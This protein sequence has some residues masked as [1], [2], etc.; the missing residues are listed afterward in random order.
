MK[1][2]KPGRPL[3]ACPHLQSQQ[4]DCPKNKGC[5]C[6]NSITVAFPKRQG[7][8]DCKTGPKTI[9]KTEGRPSG[10]AI[11]D[12]PAITAGTFKIVKKSAPLA[13]GVSRP[14]PQSYD[15]TYF[16]A[17]GL[18]SCNIIQNGSPTTPASANGMGMNGMAPPQAPVQIAPALPNLYAQNTP[19]MPM[20]FYAGMLSNGQRPR[21]SISNGAGMPFAAA[22]SEAAGFSLSNSSY[23]NGTSDYMSNGIYMAN[24]HPPQPILTSPYPISTMSTPQSYSSS[25]N[26]TTPATTVKSCCSSKKSTNSSPDNLDMTSMSQIPLQQ[27]YNAPSFSNGNGPIYSAAGMQPAYAYTANFADPSQQM[28]NGQWS[29]NFGMSYSPQQPLQ[30]LQSSNRMFQLPTSALD[31]THE[32]QCACGPDCE[33]F[34][35]QVHPQ[36]ATTLAYVRNLHN[37]MSHAPSSRESTSPITPMQQSQDLFYMAQNQSQPQIFQPHLLQNFY[38][39]SLDK[40]P[41]VTATTMAMKSE[42]PESANSRRESPQLSLNGSPYG[43]MAE[44]QQVFDDSN[45]FMVEYPI[46]GGCGGDLEGCQCGDDCQCVGCT[47]HQAVQ[48]RRQ[49][50]QEQE[51]HEIGVVKAEDGMIMP[52]NV[53]VKNSCCGW[54]AA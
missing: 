26:G 25:L 30:Q 50:E 46:E 13:A 34:G 44:T 38:N 42:T 37:Q 24:G 17:I 2:R 1:V 10:P 36:N 49:S 15:E 40:D 22:D 33:C 32:M 39:S 28:Q 18:N 31:G 35:C 20:P 51:Q 27:P 29:Q 4:C 7:C 19:P 54:T 14:R 48:E 3:T 45:Y 6:S 52:G 43:G 9:V 53:E 5:G 11:S 12:V 41:L 16:N 23:M 47:I 8:G 21:N